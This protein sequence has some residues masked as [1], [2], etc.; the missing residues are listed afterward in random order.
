MKEQQ[1]T[2]PTI[3]IHV[4]KQHVMHTASVEDF[5]EKSEEIIG[6]DDEDS[7]CLEL[8]YECYKDCFACYAPD[9]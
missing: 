5:E 6:D 9:G 4:I 3:Y 7:R 2:Q 1:Y 8:E